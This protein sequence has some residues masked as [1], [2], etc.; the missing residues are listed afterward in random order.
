ML[1]FAA[2]LA[3]V[4]SL[5]PFTTSAAVPDPAWLARLN[6]LRGAA[7]AGPVVDDPWRDGAA[8]LHARYVVMTGQPGHGEDRSSPY[9]TP[10]GST[11]GMLSL[12]DWFPTDV[13]ETDLI[14]AWAAM[15][16]HALAMFDPAMRNVGFARY[17]DPT[18]LIETAGD[19]FLG[20]GWGS[21]GPTDAPLYWPADGAGV[22]LGS[23]FVGEHPD[24]LISCGYQTGGLPIL[25]ARGL[26]RGAAHLDG[27]QLRR[28]GESIEA[29]A[30]DTTTYHN[31]DSADQALGRGILAAYGAIVIIPR[32]PLRPGSTYRVTLR[33][34]GQPT[35]WEFSVGLP[36]RM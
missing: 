30:F 32:E 24:P 33:V 16:F 12:V 8:A 6:Q 10:R 36:S 2:L 25:Y 28:D 20:R 35:G 21:R 31:P 13:S 27:Y 11:A 14:D 19:L 4:V 34:N 23:A 22:D 15:P 1:R 17:D 5:L 18:R 7:G 9:W 3:A 29:C 26:G